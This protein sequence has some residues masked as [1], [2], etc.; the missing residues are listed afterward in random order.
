MCNC[1]KTITSDIKF[2]NKVNI[3]SSV[4]LG[5]ISISNLD[6]PFMT[7]K[8]Y[9]KNHELVADIIRASAWQNIAE[10]ACRGNKTGY[11]YWRC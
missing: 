4:V 1:L 6:L 9:N 7:L 10:V 3:N 8:T 5:S 2:E 11:G